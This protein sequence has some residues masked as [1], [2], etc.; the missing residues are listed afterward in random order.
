[1]VR[2]VSQMGRRSP[3]ILLLLVAVAVAVAVRSGGLR[4][5]LT[6]WGCLYQGRIL[7][8]PG[9]LNRQEKQE[10]EQEQ[11]VCEDYSSI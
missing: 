7:T 11:E 9:N 1:M 2:G 5:A 6:R 10:Q 8:R 4:M 3:L